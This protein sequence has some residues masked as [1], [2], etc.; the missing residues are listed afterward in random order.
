M[1][2][3][4]YVIPIYYGRK[5]TPKCQMTQS[6]NQANLRFQRY[7]ADQGIADQSFSL[8]THMHVHTHAYACTLRTWEAEG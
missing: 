6:T 5:S 3:S 4:E 8:S 7:G 1:C 2:S